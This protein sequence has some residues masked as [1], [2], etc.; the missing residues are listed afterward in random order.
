MEILES[1]LFIFIITHFKNFNIIKNKYQKIRFSFFFFNF[2]V[3]NHKILKIRHRYI[4]KFN[5]ILYLN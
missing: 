4:L 1:M 2:N 5:I 3:K